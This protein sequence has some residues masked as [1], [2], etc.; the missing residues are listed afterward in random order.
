MILHLSTTR[1]QVF[2]EA[3]FFQLGDEACI[4]KRFRLV[5]PNIRA[6]LGDVF[7]SRLQALSDRVGDRDKRLAV[8]LVGAFEQF[9]IV[10]FQLFT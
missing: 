6:L 7:I 1:A 9:A 2:Y 8:D 3:G 4:H 5:V 10:G